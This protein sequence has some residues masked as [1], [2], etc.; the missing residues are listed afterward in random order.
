MHFHLG[1]VRNARRDYELQVGIFHYL[2]SK[3]CIYICFSLPKC[4]ICSFTL[5]RCYIRTIFACLRLALTVL[6]WWLLSELTAN[7]TASPVLTRTYTS[8][9]ALQD[10][11]S[12]LRT[13]V[14]TS[15][16][17]RHLPTTFY[18]RRASWSQQ[19]C[20]RILV[21]YTPRHLSPTNW[22]VWRKPWTRTVTSTDL[23]HSA[24]ASQESLWMS[25]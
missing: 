5:I 8:V 17:Y 25:S 9:Q 11:F 7:I 6:A 3:V 13:S 24:Y 10:S 12:Y 2:I 22:Q 21:I 19:I 23:C 1:C 20:I 4:N 15:Q 16:I 14:K 18:S